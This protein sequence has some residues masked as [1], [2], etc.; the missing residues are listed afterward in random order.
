[1]ALCAVL[2]V[3][4]LT[5]LP[6]VR[7]PYLLDDYMHAAMIDGTFLRPRGPADLY[8]FVNDADRPTLVERGLLPWWTHPELKIRFFRPLSSALRWGEQ[9]VFGERVLLFHLHS[10]AW[11]AAAV[12]AAHALYRRFFSE[13][14]ALMSAAVFALGPCH[15]LPLA[16]LANREALVSLVTGLVALMAYE[17][18]RAEGRARTGVLA[19]V[20]F[21]AAMTAGEYSLCF[22]GYVL[23]ME[24]GARGDSSVSAAPS[25]ARPGLGASRVTRLAAFALPAA[26]YLALRAALGY[27]TRGSAFYTDPFREPWAYVSRAPVRAV[28]LLAEGWLTAGTSAWGSTAPRWL[29]A[30]AVAVAAAALAVPLRRVLAAIDPRGRAAAKWL[31][32]GSFLAIVPVLAVTPAPRVLGVAM[33]G[34]A[35]IVALVLDHA[36]FTSPV[37]GARRGVAELTGLVAVALG[38]AHLVHGPVA[39]WVA[40]EDIR[41]SSASFAERASALRARLERGAGASR[42]EITVVR[43]MAGAFFGLFAVDPRGAA[44]GRWRVLSQGGHVLV[45][46]TGARSLDI[47]VGPERALH[48]TGQGSLFRSLDAPLRV[49]DVVEQPGMR[50][51]IL[52]VGPHGPTRARF[53]FDRELEG[54]WAMW[55]EE[56][57]VGLRPAILPRPGHGAPLDP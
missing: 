49:G 26:A 14:V 13:R 50:I 53:E 30:I 37:V 12:V 43:G 55:M 38:F 16:W 8:D 21:A 47:V 5:F 20:L 54:P 11:W 23:A 25:G 42:P 29:L 4:V 36:W 7:T 18:W 2:A 34:A 27:G 19:T 39:A 41:K 44:V 56:A 35:P 51:E 33:L 9:R 1:M 40:G 10:L 22:G 3:G 48:A 46:R 31:L 45:L 32:G 17:R 52:G 57:N 15:V 6:A 28:T 24:L